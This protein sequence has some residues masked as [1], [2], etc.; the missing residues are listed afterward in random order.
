MAKKITHF[1]F[2]VEQ[3]IYFSLLAGLL[4]SW[5]RHS[6]APKTGGRG[7]SQTTRRS[8]AQKIQVMQPY[9]EAPLVGLALVS[10][11]LICL[12][13]NAVAWDWLFTATQV[14]PPHRAIKTSS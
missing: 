14:R 6:K 2:Y 11:W 1:F 5:P 10:P 7:A 12:M 4:V 8:R 9:T 13:A 3:K